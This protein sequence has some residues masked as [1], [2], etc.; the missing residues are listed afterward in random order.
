MKKNETLDPEEVRLFRQAVG[1]VISIKQNI[2]VLD[3][4]TRRTRAISK[5]YKVENTPTSYY[6]ESIP[7][8]FLVSATDHIQY[9]Q[10]GIQDKLFL[11]LKRGQLP[12]SGVL[13]LHGM[14]LHN[15]KED[16][17]RFISQISMASTQ[18][19]VRIIHGKGHGSKD[20]QPKIKQYIQMWLQE[21]KNSL[22]YVSCRPADG[23]TGAIYLL[24]KSGRN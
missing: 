17:N 20:G 10:P 22:A 8:E 16:L 18:S 11:K 9:K 4:P 12:V 1:D 6:E 15:A 5:S 14:S 3:K 21:D 2:A 19:C 7:E 13:D 23:G 24:V